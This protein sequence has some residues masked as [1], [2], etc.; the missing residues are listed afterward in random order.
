LTT[1]TFGGTLTLGE[2]VALTIPGAN[3]MAL[4]VQNL[5]VAATAQLTVSGA[6]V[7]ADLAPI[8]TAASPS[9]NLG[10]VTFQNGVSVTLPDGTTPTVDGVLPGTLGL[11]LGGSTLATISRTADDDPAYS[12]VS[13][14]ADQ[15]H[16]YQGG[17]LYLLPLMS[18][19]G[20]DDQAGTNWYIDACTAAGLRAVGCERSSDVYTAS[21]YT[22]GGRPGG[23]N[24][25][26]SMGCDINHWITA[27]TG[28]SNFVH[29]HSG[30]HHLQGDSAGTSTNGYGG[31]NPVH[32]VC[33][34]PP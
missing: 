4:S 3:D 16:A 30:G 18:N 9:L 17:T 1:L 20:A 12:S 22:Q 6:I 32:P 25:W 23:V 10:S 5:A 33:A 15:S 7:L 34:T 19:P 13:W 2:G 29:F 8:A 11:E 28:W 26:G 24:G 21:D 27:N 14:F 31:T